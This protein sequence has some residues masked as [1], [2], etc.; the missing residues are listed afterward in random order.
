M[1]Q[2]FDDRYEELQEADVEPILRMALQNEGLREG[3]LRERMRASAADL[4]ISEEALARAEEDYLYQRDEQES[5]TRRQ[6]SLRRG[7]AA[8][9]AI[10]ALVTVFL[11]AINLL[12]DAGF[13]WALFPA[14]GWGLLVAI[15]FALLQV[16][17]YGREGKEARR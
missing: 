7:M 14:L 12:T 16:L 10:Y 4:G 5:Q 6:A 1:R 17:G 11:F 15:H 8:H 13:W 3:G 2:E 9:F